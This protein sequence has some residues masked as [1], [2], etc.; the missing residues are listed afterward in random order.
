MHEFRGNAGGVTYEQAG[1]CRTGLGGNVTT[2][3][4]TRTILKK[5]R[6][7]RKRKNGMIKGKMMAMECFKGERA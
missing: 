6:P 5:M 3:T 4:A 7:E 2:F 1:R